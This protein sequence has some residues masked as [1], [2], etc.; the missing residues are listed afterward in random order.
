[1]VVCSVCFC[2][3][4][5][6]YVFLRVLIVMCIYSCCYICYVLGTLYLYVALRIVCVQ[7]C[8][9]LQSPGIN[10]IAVNKY[11]ISSKGTQEIGHD[12]STAA[13]SCPPFAHL[14]G[15]KDSQ[16]TAMRTVR[17]LQ[18]LDSG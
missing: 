2:L 14:N 17:L 1:M 16:P 18:L 6:N 15:A 12:T 13:V 5:V 9:V 3:H 8:T 4:F 7:M 11:F 10:P